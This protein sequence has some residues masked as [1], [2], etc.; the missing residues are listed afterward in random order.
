MVFIFKEFSSPGT[1]LALVGVL[2][3]GRHRGNDIEA[4][5]VEGRVVGC[6]IGS[7]IGEMQ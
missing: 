1:G 7:E 2:G 3:E 5:E 4:E 6:A